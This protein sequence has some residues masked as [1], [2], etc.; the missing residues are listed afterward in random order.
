MPGA[1]SRL[2]WQ[3]WPGCDPMLER[4]HCSFPLTSLGFS[5]ICSRNLTEAL[6]CAA[7]APVALVA[8]CFQP[9]SHAF[10]E[11]GCRCCGTEDLLHW[12]ELTH[13]PGSSQQSGKV[14][15]AEGGNLGEREGCA[16][17]WRFRWWE[18]VAGVK[19]LHTPSGVLVVCGISFFIDQV[20]VVL[21]S[22]GC[23]ISL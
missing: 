13:I 17:L 18:N 7:A 16:L 19:H 14:R 12:D 3:S 15:R 21:A 1:S 23:S 20:N 9:S 22:T 2:L 4:S 10:S 5:Q 8:V 6:W 11:E